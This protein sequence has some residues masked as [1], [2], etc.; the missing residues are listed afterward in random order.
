MPVTAKGGHGGGHSSGHSSGGGGGGSEKTCYK[1]FVP[2]NPTEL[3]LTMHPS[4]VQI[5][6]PMSKGDIITFSVFG[7]MVIVA[8]TYA[9]TDQNINLKALLVCSLASSYLLSSGSDGKREEQPLKKWMP[10]KS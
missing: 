4:G 5:K 7:G 6:C 8:L 10:N 1:K 9:E 2:L 3:K